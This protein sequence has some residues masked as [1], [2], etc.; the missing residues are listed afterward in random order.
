MTDPDPHPRLSPSIVATA[1]W[2]RRWLV[3][4][5]IGSYALAAIAP[6]PGLWLRGLALGDSPASVRFSLLMVSV[7]LFCGA[8][9]ID[10]SRLHELTGR[11]RGVGLALFGVWGPPIA[12]VAAWSAPATRRRAPTSSCGWPRP[13]RSRGGARRPRWR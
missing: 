13:S 8:I 2:V 5:L 6:G 4:L 12:L 7:L 3:V 9:S 1:A 10:G 11:L